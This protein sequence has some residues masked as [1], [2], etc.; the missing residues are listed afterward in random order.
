[1]PTDAELMKRVAIV[2]ARVATALIR[3]EGMRAANAERERHGHALA[4]D[5]EAFEALIVEEGVH[6]N[7]VMAALND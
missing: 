5:E 3:L 7:A 1:M 4:Y 2:Q 6:H